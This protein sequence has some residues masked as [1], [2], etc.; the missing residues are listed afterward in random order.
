MCF[1]AELMMVASLGYIGFHTYSHPFGKYLTGLGLPLLAIILWGIFAAPRSAYRLE[2]P[3]RT[4][5]ALVL[6]GITAL[7]LYRYDQVGIAITFGSIALLSQLLA[8]V[9]KQ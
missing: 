7:L 5:F 2:S 9:L 6:F 4:L 3:F 1:L 8:L